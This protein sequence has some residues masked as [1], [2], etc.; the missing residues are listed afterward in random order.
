MPIGS[1][2]ITTL[3]GYFKVNDNKI[4]SISLNTFRD[5]LQIHVYNFSNNP[6]SS[7]YHLEINNGVLVIKDRFI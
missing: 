3:D 7:E 5:M 4:T 2:F 6:I 1:I